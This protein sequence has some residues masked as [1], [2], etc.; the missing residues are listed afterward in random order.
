MNHRYHALRLC[1]LSGTSA[2]HG[3]EPSLNLDVTDSATRLLNDFRNRKPAVLLA[4]LSVP[5]ARQRMNLSDTAIKLV[6]NASGDYVGVITVGALNSEQPLGLAS[7]RGVKAKDILVQDI[8]IPITHLPAI[9]Y[10]DLLEASV[11]ELV[12]TFNDTHKPCL[13]VMDEDQ[14]QDVALRG[15]ILAADLAAG[16]RISL[17]MQPRADSFSAI[18]NAVQGRY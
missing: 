12:S 9:H 6:V 11:G 18:V 16:L 5:E 17:D 3:V 8:M 14:D 7:R 1:N 15:M 10:R 2:V 13:L 4:Q